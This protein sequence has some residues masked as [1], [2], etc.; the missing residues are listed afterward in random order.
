MKAQRQNLENDPYVQLTPFPLTCRFLETDRFAT[1]FRQWHASN[2]RDSEMTFK[3]QL[4]PGKPWQMQPDSHLH[5][6]CRHEMTYCN[7]LVSQGGKC[8]MVFLMGLSVAK[9]PIRDVICRGRTCQN[10]LTK[11]GCVCVC[12][13]VCVL[14]GQAAWRKHIWL[15]FIGKGSVFL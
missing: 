11:E 9:E 14:R 4:A 1:T 7:A 8:W 15:S 5:L 10:E 3:W 12:V 13:H 6:A 2:G